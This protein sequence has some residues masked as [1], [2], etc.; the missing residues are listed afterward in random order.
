MGE[1][2]ST[3]LVCNFLLFFIFFCHSHRRYRNPFQHTELR[4]VLASH[5]MTR[6]CAMVQSLLTFLPYKH[7]E[8]RD[9]IDIAKAANLAEQP[10]DF[11]GDVGLAGPG[12]T[13]YLI[14]TPSPDPR[15][16]MKT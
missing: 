2:K 9:E 10:E 13:V 16:K 15:G 6:N 14:P 12:D 1:D 11:H 5:P 8:S 4:W 7:V 3:I